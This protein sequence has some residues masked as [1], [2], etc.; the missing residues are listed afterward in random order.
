MLDSFGRSS[1]GSPTMGDFTKQL[2]STTKSVMTGTSGRSEGGMDKLYDA[3]NLV[4]QRIDAGASNELNS[5]RQHTQ[6]VASLHKQMRDLNTTSQKDNKEQQEQSRYLKNAAQSLSSFLKEAKSQ[7]TLWFGV[8][9]FGSRGYSQIVQAIREALGKGSAAARAGVGAG[10]G[11]GRGVS[12]TSGPGVTGGSRPPS[13]P[14]GTTG[15]VG[16][17]G[18]SPGGS[19]AGMSIKGALA[20]QTAAFVITAAATQLAAAGRAFMASVD[21][22]LGQVF[23]GLIKDENLFKE[24][25]RQIVYQTQG[26]TGANRELEAEYF[27]IDGLVQRTGYNRSEF[28]R[29]WLQNM[30]RGF[31]LESKAEAREMKTAKG[32]E[33]LTQRHVRDMKEITITALHTSKQTGIS[34]DNLNDMFMSMQYGMGMSANQVQIV[35]AG[36]RAIGRDLGLTGDQLGKA[37]ASAEK[38]MQK[39]ADAGTLTAEAAEGLA[40]TMAAAT[41][42]NVEGL[43]S[44]LMQATTDFDGWLSSSDEMKRLLRLTSNQTGISMQ[45]IMTGQQT[46]TEF[47]QRELLSGV[48]DTLKTTFSNIAGDLRGI[49]PG[50]QEDLDAGK[51]GDVLQ[52][53]NAAGRSDIA[54]RLEATFKRLTGVGIGEAQRTI[55][56]IEERNMSHNERMLKMQDEYNKAVADGSISAQ[57]EIKSR[58]AASNMDMVS[59]IGRTMQ[60]LRANGFGMAEAQEQMIHDLAGQFMEDGDTLAQA[61]EKARQQIPDLLNGDAI[62]TGI[63]DRIS[64]VNRQGGSLDMGKLLQKY[65]GEFGINSMEAL[66]DGMARG[67]ADANAA[68]TAMN[69][70]ITDEERALTDPMTGM[71]KDLHEIND[72]LRSWSQGVLGRIGTSLLWIVGVGSEI[73][74][75]V[76]SIAGILMGISSIFKYFTGEGLF[77]AVS[78]GMSGPMKGITGVLGKLAGPLQIAVGAVTGMVEA[79]DNGRTTSEG[80]VLGALTG[81]AGTGS[82]FSGMLGVE[83]GSKTDKALGVVGGAAW[84]AA[85]GAAIGSAFFGVGAAPGAAIGAV[86]GGAMEMVKIITEGTNVLAHTLAPLQV[87]FDFITGQLDAWWKVIK[88]IFT[89][90]FNLIMEGATQ[91]LTNLLLLIPQLLWAG[92]KTVVSGIPRLLL[93]SLKF[94]YLELPKMIWDGLKNMFENLAQNEWVGPIFQTISE[95]FNELYDGFMAI[96]TPFK[97]AWDAIY[98]I[99]TE[100]S[101]AL[102]GA[103]EDGGMFKTVLGWVKWGIQGLAKVL[104]FLLKPLVWVAQ[105]IGAVM[106][107]VGWLVSG[108]VAPFKWLY[109]VLVGH[110]IIPDLVTGIIKFFLMLPINIMKALWNLGTSMLNWAVG[111]LGKLPGMLWDFLKQVPGLIW[112]AVKGIGGLIVD[113]LAGIGNLILDGLQAVFVDFPTWLFD[114]ITT[115]LGN[116]GTWL[117]DNTIGLLIDAIPDW[118]KNLFNDENSVLKDEGGGTILGEAGETLSDVAGGAGRMT[119]GAGGKL[120]EGD[121]LGAAGEVLGGAKDMVVGAVDGI[122][123][124]GSAVLSAVNPLNWFEEGTREIAKPGVAV[125]HEGEMVVPKSI[126]EQI[127]AV[128]SGPFGGGGSIWDGISGFLTNPLGLFGSMTGMSGT[129]GSITGQPEK[130]DPFEEVL[131]EIRDIHGVLN[132]W[133]TQSSDEMLEAILTGNEILYGILDILSQESESGI[134]D[135]LKQLIDGQKVLTHVNAAILGAFTGET[136]AEALTAATKSALDENG[137]KTKEGVEKGA[138]KAE[139][140][141][142]MLQLLEFMAKDIGR[143]REVMTG[144]YSAMSESLMEAANQ[145]DKS[146]ES[147]ESSMKEMGAFGEGA[148]EGLMAGMESMVDSIYGEGA[149]KSIQN[150]FGLGSGAIGIGSAAAGGTGGAGG[151]GGGFSFGGLLENAGKGALLGTALGGPVFGGMIGAGV[152]VG[153]YLLDS[154]TGKNKTGQSSAIG[155]GAF[156]SGETKEASEMGM[157]SALANSPLAGKE[158]PGANGGIAG[159][160]SRGGGMSGGLMQEIADNIF[161]IASNVYDILNVLIE[162]TGVGIGSS[163]SSSLGLFDGSIISDA[164]NYAADVASSAWSSFADNTTIGSDI[165]KWFQKNGTD[166]ESLIQSLPEK[167]GFTSSAAKNMGVFDSE[168]SIFDSMM[169]YFG[170]SS[171][172]D[173]YDSARSSTTSADYETP[174][175]SLA[176]SMYYENMGE[177]GEGTGVFGGVTSGA[178]PSGEMGFWKWLTAPFEKGGILGP[179][180]MDYTDNMKGQVNPQMMNVQQLE[181]AVA[182][183]LMNAQSEMASA[184]EGDDTDDT[185]LFKLMVKFLEVIAQN[186]TPSQFSQIVGNTKFGVPPA[187]GSGIK[188]TANDLLSSYWNIQHGEGSTANVNNDGRGGK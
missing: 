187:R 58:M 96:Y 9:K 72:M 62:S 21:L 128:G 66:Q 84:G 8:A 86:I 56:A 18:S 55:Q 83:K 43:A 44:S 54:I 6:S 33:K 11:R 46:S 133:K 61:M 87:I 175:I 91:G 24:N 60:E 135:H 125:L 37:L 140:K 136:V 27:K 80:A 63:Q 149:S 25:M 143:I 40:R 38:L 48:S 182:S 178:T 76:G 52:K 32:R 126:W 161:S 141:Y 188:R 106:K 17:P 97:E 10:R 19:T 116:L 73:V 82:M 74:L 158:I 154:L 14:G 77:A 100:I 177:G 134:V 30:Q 99:F 180:M 29:L 79:K 117:W 142:G 105:A 45:G 150:A 120:L 69:Q 118:V 115:G 148:S 49:A 70:A 132:E 7:N 139:K 110:S 28:Q 162:S 5:A 42:H 168:E 59:R 131:K 157:M 163:S 113:G 71:R 165:D 164:V 108:I 50:I 151:A 65:G 95:A 167:M 147:I 1:G 122:L 39:M 20:W 137:E 119:L 112:D 16:G 53:L 124:T 183:R 4:A 26:L 35:G 36:I 186:T 171:V 78:R 23:D 51:L 101:E 102:F 109:D 173:K 103:S 89:F 85:A 111:F 130:V 170:L 67:D 129:S 114:T 15:G 160:M 81:G 22:N 123:D 107:V 93:L 153:E 57:R 94:L 159:L 88:G 2:L 138:E 121:V 90:D 98:G 13:V 185:E 145:S 75:A 152:G 166:V 104:G 184:M 144:E 34:A 155:I 3:V 176:R 41:K 181:T 64:Q 156:A 172:N 174:E 68:F 12:I 47:G 146:S 92:L 169:N 31:K 179:N 127:A